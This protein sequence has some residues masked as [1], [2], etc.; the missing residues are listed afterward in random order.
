MV[1]RLWG[2]AAAMPCPHGCTPAGGVVEDRRAM[3]WLMAILEL[4]GHHLVADP[5]VRDMLQVAQNDDVA[6]GLLA[7]YLRGDRSVA[8]ALGARLLALQ[9]D[10]GAGQAPASSVGGQSGVV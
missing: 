7:R 10:R 8:P 2:T 9:D 1:C 6:A 3:S 4:G 5:R